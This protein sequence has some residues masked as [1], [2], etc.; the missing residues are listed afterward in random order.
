MKTSSRI[1]QFLDTNETATVE[2][3]SQALDLT[4]ADIHYHIRLLLKQGEVGILEQPFQSGAGRPAR[5]FMLI[6]PAPESLSSV[7]ISTLVQDFP[8]LVDNKRY[9]IEPAHLLAMGIL[10]R[11]CGNLD[12]RLSPTIRLITIIK[13]L[14]FYGIHLR[15]RAG[16]TGPVI[17]VEQEYLSTLIK[18]KGLVHETLETLIS[19][20]IKKIV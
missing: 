4:K 10:E 12:P 13:E 1:K 18:D 8:C 11:S 9:R 6:K 2:Q 20:I 3:L 17:K 14:S 7:I 19:E 5:Q 15:W 16:S